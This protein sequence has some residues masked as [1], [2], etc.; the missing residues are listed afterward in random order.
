VNAVIASRESVALNCV[1]PYPSA[2]MFLGIANTDVTR[3]R[4]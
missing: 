1:L 3:R 2:A 4:F